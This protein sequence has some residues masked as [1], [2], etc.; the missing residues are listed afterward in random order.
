VRLP[1]ERRA[2]DQGMLINLAAV[3]GVIA[4]IL[5]LTMGA[6]VLAGLGQPVPEW[7]GNAVIGG[8]G[9]LIGCLNREPKALPGAGPIQHVEELNVSS[10]EPPAPAPPVEPAV[11]L[12][13][14]ERD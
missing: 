2:Q 8:V 12:P 13:L 9:G 7:V 11:T 1:V 14:E 10:G 4:V 6:V 5:I 3:R